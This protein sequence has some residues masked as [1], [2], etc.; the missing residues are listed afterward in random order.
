LKEEARLRLHAD[1]L[2]DGGVSADDDGVVNNLQQQLSL[3][4]RVSL[5][6]SVA[7]IFVFYLFGS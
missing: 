3:A 7:F 1:G 2:R 6:C 5:C 4:I